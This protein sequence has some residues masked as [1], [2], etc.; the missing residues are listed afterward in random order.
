MQLKQRVQWVIL[1]D[2]R[3]IL[4]V[5]VLQIVVVSLTTKRETINLV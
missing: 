3:V 4:V 5:L 2:K 1:V